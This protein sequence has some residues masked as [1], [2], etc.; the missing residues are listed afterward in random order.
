MKWKFFI[1]RS[2]VLLS[3]TSNIFIFVSRVTTDIIFPGKP[4]RQAD[5]RASAKRSPLFALV[6]SWVDEFRPLNQR[7][8]GPLDFVRSCLNGLDCR[9]DP[10]GVLNRRRRIQCRRLDTGSLNSQAE[11]GGAKR[12][13]TADLLNAIQALSQLSYSPTDQN[14]HWGAG[15]Y[16]GRKIAPPAEKSIAFRLF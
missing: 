5:I 1:N 2:S 15:R 11:F 16:G 9:C 6:R 10:A 13:R 4:Q 3:R 12:N 7:L 14:R 8:R